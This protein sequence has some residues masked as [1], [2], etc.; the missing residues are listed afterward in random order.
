[1]TLPK[2]PVLAA[3][4]LAVAFPFVAG[5]YWTHVMTIAY[6]YALVAASWS[7]IAGFSGQFSFGQMAMVT[8]GAYTSGF[9]SLNIGVPPLIGLLAGGAMAAAASY[10]LGSLCL[11]MRGPYLA[12]TTIAFSESFR[13]IM[14]SEFEVTRGTLGL[15]VPPLVA[16]WGAFKMPYYFLMLAVLGISLFVM[17]RILSSRLGLFFRSIRE[18]E[19]AASVMGVDTTKYKILAF[20]I[21]GFFAGVAGAFFGHYLQLVSPI[22][23]SLGEMGLVISMVVVGGT[24]S[25]AGP[26]MG[27]LM[28][29]V[30][31]EYFRVYGELYKVL[32]GLL[33]ILTLRF[34]PRGLLLPL[35]KRAAAKI[36]PQLG[37]RPS[38]ARPISMHQGH[39]ST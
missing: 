33:M 31:S 9:L 7:L 27:A 23:G 28:L 34:M 29:E 8:I 11:R 24:E 4:A 21:G 38:T 6:Y 37:I 22:M 16:Q 2:L 15:S 3:L 32:F 14:S 30:A 10:G 18:D 26:V 13:L 20:T 12:L 39:G 36:G 25:L 19:D 1:L 17:A 5:G 35:L